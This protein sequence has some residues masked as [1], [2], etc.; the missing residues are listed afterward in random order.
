MNFS[1]MSG[2]SDALLLEAHALLARE[3]G[4]AELLGLDLEGARDDAGLLGAVLAGLLSAPAARL[5]VRAAAAE[6]FVPGSAAMEAAMADLDVTWRKD[7]QA[8]GAITALLFNRG[9]HALLCYRLTHCLWVGGRRDLALAVK[10]ALERVLC[11]DI[12]PAAD[13]AKGVWLDHG[14][15]FVVGE[16]AVIEEGVSIWHAVTL[17]S[18]L[19]QS[20]ANRHPRIRQGATLG[21]GV[22]V[23]G[24]IE[25]GRGA[26]VAAGSVVVRDVPADTTVAGVPAQAKIRGAASF[27]GI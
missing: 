15:G 26:V 4:A 17:G 18:S 11:V 10:A 8:G 16:T 3:P 20:G 7:F 27:Q 21:A 6:V 12:H 25:V 22:I 24:S 9:L 5:V 14:L 19:K 1:V 23:L 2:R 13:I